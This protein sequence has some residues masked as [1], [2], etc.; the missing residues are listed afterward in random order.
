MLKSE[1]IVASTAQLGELN[2]RYGANYKYVG[3]Y[4]LRPGVDLMLLVRKDLA[5]ADAKE[6]FTLTDVAK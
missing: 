1:L 6:I 4:P 3:T 2:K 5:N